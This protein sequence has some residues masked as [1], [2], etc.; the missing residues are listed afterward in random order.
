MSIAKL[1]RPLAQVRKTPINPPRERVSFCC[2]APQARTVR[3]VGDFNGWDIAATPMQW[4]PD[5]SWVASLE[6]NEGYQ[7]YLFL[8][9]GKPT[10][11]PR[12]MRKAGVSRFAVS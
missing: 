10:L 8:V 1:A 7:H 4:R 3:L 5:G 6:V 2:Y 9:D 12:A 11:D